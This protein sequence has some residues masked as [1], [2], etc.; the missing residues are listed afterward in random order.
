M[1][2]T[3]EQN[4][5]AKVCRKRKGF[6]FSTL[7]SVIILAVEIAR[8]GREGKKIDTKNGPL[9][10]KSHLGKQYWSSIGCG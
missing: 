7:E 6:N 9:F 8:E 5:I 2:K 1:S 10:L 3:K 4:L